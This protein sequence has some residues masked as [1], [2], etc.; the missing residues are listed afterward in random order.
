MEGGGGVEE[1]NRLGE[2]SASMFRICHAVQLDREKHWHA[3]SLKLT[4]STINLQLYF[5][6]DISSSYSAPFLIYASS[7]I[8]HSMRSGEESES[9]ASIR[10]V[11]SFGSP[12]TVFQAPSHL[13]NSGCSGVC[14]G[15]RGSQTGL[16]LRTGH[17]MSSPMFKLR[18]ILPQGEVPTP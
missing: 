10:F 8:S 3:Q 18:K 4:P 11:L 7:D 2:G 9:I 5:P 12:Y 1:K 13:A 14:F 16:S 15:S 6:L 17:V